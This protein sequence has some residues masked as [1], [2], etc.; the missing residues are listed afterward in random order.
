MLFHTVP[1]PSALR[2]GVPA[3]L[4]RVAMRLLALNPEDRYQ[5]A[6][7]AT[8]E[9]ARCADARH[10]GR[11]EL[12]KLLSKRCPLDRAAKALE[13]EA[14]AHGEGPLER[15][16]GVSTLTEPPEAEARRRAPWRDPY[17]A[18]LEEQLARR[19]RWRWAYGVLIACVIAAEL[20][21]NAWR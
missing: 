8:L 17:I 21:L 10:D 20:L 2:Q 1:P 3:D 4:E 16:E 11:D 19:T 9:L 5:T 18:R 13:R 12:A 15:R 6:A 14:K 7:E